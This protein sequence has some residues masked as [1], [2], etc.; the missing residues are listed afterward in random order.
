MD[1]YL[2]TKKNT[3]MPFVATW[4]QQETIILSE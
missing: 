3:T 1:Y 4:M 2:A